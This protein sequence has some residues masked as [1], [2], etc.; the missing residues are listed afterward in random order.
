MVLDPNFASGAIRC[1]L[2]ATVLVSVVSTAQAEPGRIGQWLMNE[3]VSLWDLG[4][5]RAREEAKRAADAHNHVFDDTRDIFSPR[6]EFFNGYVGYNWDNNEIE[7]GVTVVV[8]HEDT[9]HEICNQLRRS[10]IVAL[11]GRPLG[12]L[13]FKV[14][15]PELQDLKLLHMIDGWFSH[16]GYRNKDRDEMLA[17]KLSRIIFVRVDVL[18]DKDP[19]KNI[20]CRERIMTFDAPSQPLDYRESAQ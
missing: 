12:R 17:E 14:I 8:R 9:S 3:P 1:A 2:A 16:Y 18:D 6:L 13:P 19:Y 11:S 7:I 15:D 4:M 20:T 5:M 10:F